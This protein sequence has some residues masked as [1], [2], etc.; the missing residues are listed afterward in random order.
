MKVRPSSV[1]PISKMLQMAGCSSEEAALASWT[2]LAW[3]VSSRSAFE[4]RILTATRPPCSGA[5]PS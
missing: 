5:W 3:L 1:S 4:E 2:N